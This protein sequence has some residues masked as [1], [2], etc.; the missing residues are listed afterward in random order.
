MSTPDY[1]AGYPETLQQQ[2]TSLLLNG[3]LGHYL[4]Q[5]YPES[6]PVQNDKALYNYVCTLKNRY[7]KKAA[8]LSQARFDNK[9]NI[10]RQALGLHTYQARLQGNKLKTRNSIT[11][12]ALFREGPPEFLRMIVVHELAHFREKEHNKAFYQLCCHMEPDYH[13]LELD[14]RLW[15]LWRDHTRPA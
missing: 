4:E 1:L 9:L 12:A 14:T 3:R 10:V 6:H 13:Q 8:P 7:M 2:A 15:L 5:K 11:V